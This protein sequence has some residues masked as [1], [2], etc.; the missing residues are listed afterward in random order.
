MLLRRR[1]SATQPPRLALFPEVPPRGS[2]PTHE[3]CVLIHA[4]V[5][6]FQVAFGEACSLLSAAGTS[7]ALVF[8]S[9]ASREILSESR[10][11]SSPTSV[12]TVA[13]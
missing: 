1:F 11:V 9:A 13:K 6:C 3:L 5:F 4:F 2:S 7:G 10:S 12:K 8:L